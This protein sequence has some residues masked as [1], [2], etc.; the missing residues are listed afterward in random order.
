MKRIGIGAVLAVTSVC[1]HRL[2]QRAAE[3]QAGMSSEL[4]Q[5]TYAEILDTDGDGKICWGDFSDFVV[6]SYREAHPGKVG[7]DIT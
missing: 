4:A 7:N 3:T 6:R 2:E 5:A 1:G